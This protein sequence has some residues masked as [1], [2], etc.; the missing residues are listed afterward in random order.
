MLSYYIELVGN[1]VEQNRNRYV[2]LLFFCVSHTK[3]IIKYLS[4]FMTNADPSKRKKF[5]GLSAF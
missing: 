1:V 2:L 4:S 3:R 5:F